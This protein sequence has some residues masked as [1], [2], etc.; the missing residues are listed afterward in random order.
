M[1]ITNQ[2]APKPAATND[3][4]IRFLVENPEMIFMVQSSPP[5]LLSSPTVNAV[6]ESPENENTAAFVFR[7][8]FNVFWKSDGY[9][10]KNVSLFVFWRLLIAL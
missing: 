4:K 3:M 5:P 1:V 8:T 10:G 9:T 2:D 6:Q 7:S